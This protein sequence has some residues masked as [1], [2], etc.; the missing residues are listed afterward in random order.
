MIILA[1][2]IFALVMLFSWLFYHI[3]H[4]EGY[5][6]GQAK[7]YADWDRQIE[8]DYMRRKEGR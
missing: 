8:R 6:K 7:V 5:V 2:C 1:L 4:H 3:G